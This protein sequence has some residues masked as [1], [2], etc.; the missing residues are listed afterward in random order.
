[1]SWTVMI[2]YLQTI[3]LEIMVSRI[4]LQGNQEPVSRHIPVKYTEDVTED[5]VVTSKLSGSYIPCFSVYVKS[6]SEITQYSEV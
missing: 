6:L 5:G 4:S 1:M 2:R 3:E